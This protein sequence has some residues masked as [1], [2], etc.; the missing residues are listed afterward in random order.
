MARSPQLTAELTGVDPS[1]LVGE[2]QGEPGDGHLGEHLGKF[3]AA[4]STE[5]CRAT[6]E[7]LLEAGAD[8]VVLVPNPAGRHSTTQMIDQMRRASALVQPSTA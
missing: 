1:L 5:S 7:R 2:E 6:I 3:A 4:G 8:R